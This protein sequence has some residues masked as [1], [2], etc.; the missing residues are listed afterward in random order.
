MGQGGILG[1]DIKFHVPEVFIIGLHMYYCSI[2]CDVA[3]F[4]G[5]RQTYV[6]W[7]TPDE[8]VLV[9]P[10]GSLGFEVIFER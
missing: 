8:R 10:K 7:E 2:D 5:E 6:L 3:N 1:K 4:T 9:S